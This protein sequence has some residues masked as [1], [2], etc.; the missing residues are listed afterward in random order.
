MGVERS[1]MWRMQI[2]NP[3]VEFPP[4]L[5]THTNNEYSSWPL[6]LIVSLN[7]LWVLVMSMHI[8][9]GDFTTLWPINVQVAK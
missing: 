1:T 6:G 8:H 2:G 9:I 5:L 4:T 7:W 3:T